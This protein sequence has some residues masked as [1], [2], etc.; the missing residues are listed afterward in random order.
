MSL[1]VHKVCLKSVISLVRGGCLSKKV[2]AGITVERSAQQRNAE[3]SAE[4]SRGAGSSITFPV[5]DVTPPLEMEANKKGVTFQ[6]SGG[7]PCTGMVIKELENI[8]HGHAAKGV[9]TLMAA[10]ISTTSQ[11]RTAI[12][13]M[14][15]KARRTQIQGGQVWSLDLQTARQ[16]N[17]QRK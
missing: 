1:Q 2:S 3:I 7:I 16:E 17:I 15:V 12:S 4:I 6:H 10:D 8:V 9:G 13:L 11:A 5:A 14:E